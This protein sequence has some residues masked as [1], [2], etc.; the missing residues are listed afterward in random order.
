MVFSGTCCTNS[1]SEFFIGKWHIINVV[2]ND[3]SIDLN[4]NW[5]HLKSDGTFNSYDGDSDKKEKGKWTYSVSEK[6]LYI[7]GDL[8]NSDDSEWIMSFKNDTLFFSAKKD[9]L[10]LIAKKMK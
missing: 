8:S 6:V 1:S 4:D 2:E 5:M 7:D 3:Q 9:K 10:F